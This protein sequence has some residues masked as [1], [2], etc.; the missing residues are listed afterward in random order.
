MI[1]QA[2]LLLKKDTGS[3]ALKLFSGILK[4]RVY[5]MQCIAF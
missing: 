1:D 4:L 3:A 2:R 5:T